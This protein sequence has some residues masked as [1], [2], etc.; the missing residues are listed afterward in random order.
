MAKQPFTIEENPK[1]TLIHLIAD[2]NHENCSEL[3]QAIITAASKVAVSAGTGIVLDLG[4][5][6]NI[7]LYFLKEV[8][9]I[10]KVIKDNR[11]GIAAASCPAPTLKLL[12]EL[13]MDSM[14]PTFLNVEKALTH[15]GIAIPK[16]P[17]K[18]DVAFVNPF[19]SGALETLKVQC[20][21]TVTPG[22]PF[23]KGLNQPTDVAIA[24]VLGLT[25]KPFNGSIALCFPE[26]TFLTIMGKMLGEA[27]PAITKDLEDGAGELL[28]IIFGQAKKHL[29]DKGYAIEKA[30]PTIVRG[31]ELMVRHMS[32]NPTVILPFESDAGLFHIEVSTEP[33]ALK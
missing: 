18:I 19:V 10:A 21:T 7:D 4:Q 29:N 2:I 12:K 28:N 11:S 32:A 5:K 9:P 27:F 16:D 15:L 14:L 22:K 24:A 23:I 3:T 20:S 26:K 33:N 31:K 13:G 17:V 1:Y 30:I 8:A 6:W 25:S